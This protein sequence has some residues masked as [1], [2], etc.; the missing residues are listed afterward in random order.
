MPGGEITQ[1]QRDRFAEAIVGG[2]RIHSAADRAHDAAYYAQQLSG[3][4]AET[5]PI[6]SP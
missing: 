5:Q 4:Q 1:A 3:H 2:A 6:E